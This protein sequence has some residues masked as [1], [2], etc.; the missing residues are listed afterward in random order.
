[1]SS[2]PLPLPAATQIATGS[3]RGAKNAKQPKE[4]NKLPTTA[5]VAVP[6]PTVPTPPLRM[7]AFPGVTGNHDQL[8]QEDSTTPAQASLAPTEGSAETG[9]SA[10]SRAAGA[11]SL[12]EASNPPAP[13]QPPLAP[14]GYLAFAFPGV[15]GNHDQLAQEDSTTPA[16]ASLAPGDG[17]AETGR[18]AASRAASANALREASNSPAPEQPPLAP[19]GDLAI[20]ARV[21]PASPASEALPVSL[22]PL[23][24]ETAAAAHLS[25]KKPTESD[26]AAPAT[27]QPIAGGTGAA[28]NSYGHA[29]TNPEVS[30]APATPSPT[31]PKPVEA[32]W[33]PQSQPKAAA[34][35]LKDISFQVAQS[36]TQKVEVRVVQ[37]S[38]ELRVAVRTGDSDLAHGLQQ[39]LSDLVGRLQENGFR[40][41]AWR[42]GGYTVQAAPASESRNSQSSSQ[43]R[44]SQSYS[45]SHQQEGERRQSQSN[46]PGWVEEMENSTTGSEQSQGVN[47]GIGS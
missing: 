27:V 10:A 9:R 47:Y 45:G 31:P 18:S 25:S 38:G 23:Q 39:G 22:R 46:R 32:A 40:T 13:D 44:D 20:A 16:Q 42:P 35:P 19:A 41:E 43:D 1:M 3:H 2:L 36:G 8:A 6:L 29:P 5:A 7:Q 37:Q 26:A 34:A 30:A 14:A 11:N 24:P 28:L 12:R 4:E 33:A 17:S 21:Q 15:T